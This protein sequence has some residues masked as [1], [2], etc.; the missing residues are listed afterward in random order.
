FEERKTNYRAPEYRNFSYVLLTPETL[1]DPDAVTD[2]QARQDYERTLDRFTTP[3]QRHVRQIVF[4]SREEAEA[5]R[6]KIEEGSDFGEVVASEG[7]TEADVS[8][9]LIRRQ[10][11][12]DAAIAEAA[13]ALEE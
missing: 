8:L 2:E 12:A 1:A 4:A 13:F 6:R 9:G 5:A 11:I 3:E 10:D 7:K